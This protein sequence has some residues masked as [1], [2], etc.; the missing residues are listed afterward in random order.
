ML[1]VHV[2]ITSIRQLKHVLTT[3]DTEKKENHFENN[4]FQVSCPLSLP[5]HNMP[6]NVKMANYVYLHDT[7]II[8]FDFKYYNFAKLVSAQF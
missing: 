2:G 5:L 3:Y 7:I 6:F 8:K 1:S 4:V